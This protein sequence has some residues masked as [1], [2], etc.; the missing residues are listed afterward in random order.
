MPG[1]SIKED[2]FDSDSDNDRG[3]SSSVS[4]AE[5]IQ[6]NVKFA[7]QYEKKKQAEELTKHHNKLV[8]ALDDSDVE[9]SSYDESSSESEDEMAELLTDDLN[10][11]ILKTVHAIRNS[12]ENPDVYDSSKRFFNDDDVPDL[13]KEGLSKKRSK[14]HYKDVI[15][16]Q[17]IEQMDDDGEKGTQMSDR[18]TMHNGHNSNLAYDDE[19]R[20]LREE[21]LNEEVDVDGT[22]LEEDADFLKIRSSSNDKNTKRSAEVARETENYLSSTLNTDEGL[23]DP[24]GE[25]K[26]GNAFLRDFL[27]NKKWIEKDFTRVGEVNNENDDLED[28]EELDRQDMFESQYNFRFEESSGGDGVPQIVSY[29]R[30]GAA[31]KDSLRRKDETR[32]LKRQ[33]RKERKAEERKKKEEQLKRL[34][35][36]KKAE[37]QAKIRTVEEVCGKGFGENFDEATLEK[38]LEGDFDE[39]EFENM[40]HNE[41]LGNEYEDGIAG[42]TDV[43][44]G[45][46]PDEN[47]LDEEMENDEE[48]G[49][50]EVH[51]NHQYNNDEN[52]DNFQEEIVTSELSRKLNEKMEDALYKLDYED[53]IGGDIKCRFK[54]QKVEPNRFGLTSQEILLAPDKE[55]NAYVSL[56]RMVPYREGE[57]FDPGSKKRRKFRE[58]VRD[59][60]VVMTEKVEKALNRKDKKSNKADA[61]ETIKNEEPKKKRRRKKKGRKGENKE[62]ITFSTEENA[63]YQTSLDK[64]SEGKSIEVTSLN[65]EENKS[66]EQKKKK[67]K[68]SKKGGALSIQGV[69]S[70]RLASYGI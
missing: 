32:K 60:I 45:W 35:N 26:D 1:P 33:Q 50:F 36:A 68:R 61:D 57:E 46:K 8:D 58:N 62:D 27:L 55:L 31:Y 37:M 43:K 5:K 48:A 25:V 7:A 38:M 52:L 23:E 11:K 67:R 21:F 15:R 6:I 42:E 56:K 34:R 47:R 14:K 16:E 9:N 13:K 41:L 39:E 59:D 12:K 19:Q 53:I 69:S 17:I 44:G 66:Q 24:R 54:Y 3:H 4:S 28:E 51:Q 70:S 10:L 63:N 29:A 20:K 64:C 49:D 2:I 65:P 30:G 22:D 40:L 18:S